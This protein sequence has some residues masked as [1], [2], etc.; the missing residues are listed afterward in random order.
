MNIE[1]SNS[2]RA[3]RLPNSNCQ[4]ASCLE[5]NQN[6]VEKKRMPL[7][8]K[9]KLKERK[10]KK[11]RNGKGMVSHKVFYFDLFF[12]P[13]PVTPELSSGNSNAPT[14]ECRAV[15]GQRKLVFQSHEA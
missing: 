1:K 12:N 13:L 4:D 2:P 7:C 6:R 11:E 3:E 8:S 9:E 15:F 10:R 5:R 14:L